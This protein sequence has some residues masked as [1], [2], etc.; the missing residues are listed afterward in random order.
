VLAPP[1]PTVILYC[2][3]KVIGAVA[4]TTPPPPPPPPIPPDAPAP[5]ATNKNSTAYSESNL[6]RMIQESDISIYFKQ[7]L[8]ITDDDGG[9]EFTTT[10]NF[11]V[12][13]PGNSQFYLSLSNIDFSN[14]IALDLNNNNLTY[15]SDF[16]QLN[17]TFDNSKQY[18]VVTQD[19]VKTS[20][21]SFYFKPEFLTTTPT[22]TSND[23]TLTVDSITISNIRKSPNSI[24][25]STT[26]SITSG[27][28]YTIFSNVS[29]SNNSIS[30]TPNDIL[31]SNPT[32][33]NTNQYY[34]LTNDQYTNYS[35]YY[36][37]NLTITISDTTT[38]SPFSVSNIVNTDTI[39]LSK[40]NVY[41][42]TT[43]IPINNV[44]ISN[45][46][47]NNITI[48]DCIPS[49]NLFD[50]SIP[51]YIITQTQRS[52]N[53]YQFKKYLII[54][55]LSSDGTILY[56]TLS[57]S[58]IIFN[59]EP[60][61]GEATTY[62]YLSESN[63]TLT[64]NDVYIGTYTSTSTSIEY[65]SVSSNPNFSSNKFYYLV[66]ANNLYSV[67]QSSQYYFKFQSD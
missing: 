59:F 52:L 28:V 45:N 64:N 13:G 51:Y 53:S 46:S 42:E 26:Q 31:S 2:V 24:Y 38:N 4:I 60:P 6:L 17:P 29:I 22:I 1:A 3:P 27:T 12:G 37:W 10:D 20:T 7:S 21:F 44:V 25:L 5:P 49:T 55:G 11:V 41:D 35:F 58:N 62:L 15:Y 43:A 8:V 67:C 56:N 30:I 18:Y 50:L 54:D 39:Y 34:I 16:I 36:K 63:N 65:S 47:A 66:S 19:C 48:D 40:D 9:T 23:T 33:D 61:G 57:I 32:F 14:A